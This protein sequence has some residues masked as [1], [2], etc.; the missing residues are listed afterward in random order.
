MT[1]K[2]CC[3]LVSF[4]WL[5]PLILVFAKL[6][7]VECFTWCILLAYALGYSCIIGFYLKIGGLLRSR[8]NAECMD[9]RTRVLLHHQNKRSIRLICLISVTYIITTSGILLTRIFLTIDFY[10]P[11]GFIWFK[12]NESSIRSFGQFL[13]QMNSQINPILYYSKHRIIRSEVKRYIRA[14]KRFIHA[15]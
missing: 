5:S 15:T 7:T 13:F 10:R 1:R 4:T 12:E 3:F 2:R 14:F 11:D 6:I 9:N 8:L